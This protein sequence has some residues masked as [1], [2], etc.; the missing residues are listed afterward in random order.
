MV[1]DSISHSQGTSTCKC[2]SL[3]SLY[4]PSG[5]KTMI[6]GGGGDLLFD[7]HPPRGELHH[8]LVFSV[9][10]AST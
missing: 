2:T 7:L 10:Q 9:V 5:G 6:Q 4:C 1:G 3:R 8:F